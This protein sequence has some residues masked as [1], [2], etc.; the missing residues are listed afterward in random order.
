MIAT[1]A[2]KKSPVS[3]WSV[4]TPLMPGLSCDHSWLPFPE[5]PA[6]GTPY[7]TFTPLPYGKIRR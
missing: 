4:A 5:S 2:P 1:E 7:N 3:P 6:P